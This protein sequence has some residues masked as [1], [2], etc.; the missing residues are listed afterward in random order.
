MPIKSISPLDGRYAEQLAELGDYF[1]EWALIRFRI[2][3]EVEWLIKLAAT[4]DIT[5]VREFTDAEV[6][7]LRSLVTAFDEAAAERVKD[8][9]SVTKHDVK[10]VEYY[11]K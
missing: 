8:I 4:T 5:E 7:F 2:H 11:I 3:V 9:E 6:N 1:S 10:A